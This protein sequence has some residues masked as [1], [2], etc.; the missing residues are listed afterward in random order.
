L[1]FLAA[2]AFLLPSA[3][4]AGELD[5]ARLSGN[6]S[7]RDKDQTTDGA[8]EACFDFDG[9]DD[10]EV[11]GEV[12]GVTGGCTAFIYYDTDAF[13]KASGSKT[14]SG[15]TTG[16]AKL[17]QQIFSDIE[18]GL[19]DTDF[20]GP[21]ECPDAF[22]GFAR[23][24]KCSVKSS[25]KGTQVAN[26]FADEVN[27]TVDSNKVQTK[28]DIGDNFGEIDT[29]FGTP[30][31]QPP[32]ASAVAGV[33]AAFA[34]RKDVKVDDKGRVQIKHDGVPEGGEGSTPFCD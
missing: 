24:E 15:K 34:D 22:F 23:P 7:T 1:C 8:N 11:D 3:G 10:I 20:D 25:A 14:S 29:D 16:N 26:T 6:F 28:C 32:S 27:D 19:F 31:T 17:Q 4:I 5:E 12:Q 9:D 30:G 18:V 33:I 2:G 13:N 21:G